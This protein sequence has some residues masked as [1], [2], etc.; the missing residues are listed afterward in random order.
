MFYG[1]RPKGA[2]FYARQGKF[3]MIIWN[4][5]PPGD[6]QCIGFTGRTENQFVRDILDGKY[7]HLFDRPR[8]TA[9]GMA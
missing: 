5:P 3:E 8:Q 4:A 1:E 6:S 2:K 7:N 9:E